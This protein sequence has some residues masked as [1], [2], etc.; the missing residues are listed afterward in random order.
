MDAELI[1]RLKGWFYLR[2]SAEDWTKFGSSASEV[3]QTFD[4]DPD[5]EN[6]LYRFAHTVILVELQ[7]KFPS[8]PRGPGIGDQ[9]VKLMGQRMGELAQ[10]GIDMEQFYAASR[11]LF[12]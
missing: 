2:L 11:S 8:P 3:L 1:K 6:A 4:N 7:T 5:Q 9:A 12:K 10:L